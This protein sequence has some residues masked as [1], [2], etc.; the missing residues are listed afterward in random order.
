M[1]RSELHIRVTTGEYK[2][3]RADPVLFLNALG[4]EVHSG[5]YAEVVSENDRCV[6]TKKIGDAGRIATSLDP[7]EDNADVA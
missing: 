5:K 1:R 7:R 3:V 4:H 2:T 6:I